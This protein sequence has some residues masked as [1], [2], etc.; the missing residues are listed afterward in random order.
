MTN[1]SALLPPTNGGLTNN[2]FDQSTSRTTANLW[3]LKLD[4]TISNK[5]AISF[6]FDYANT[7]TGGT[8]DTGAFPRITD[9]ARHAVCPLQPQLHLHSK[10][11]KPVSCGIQSPV[12][13]GG[14]QRLRSEI[15]PKNWA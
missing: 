3:D 12:S 10:R 8:L 6:G 11:G 13:N 4:Q 1:V 14:I 9:T 7:K 5:Q 2:V 15:G